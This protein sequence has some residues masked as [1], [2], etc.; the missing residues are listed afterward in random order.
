MLHTVHQLCRPKKT[1]KPSKIKNTVIKKALK[2]FDSKC[3]ALQLLGGITFLE[4]YR[5][6]SNCMKLLQARKG[7]CFRGSTLVSLAV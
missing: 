7:K 4:Y 6:Y 5:Y 2:T 1:R 3:S